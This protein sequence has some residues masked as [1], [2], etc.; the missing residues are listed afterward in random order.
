METRRPAGTIGQT[1]GNMNPSSLGHREKIKDRNKKI[2]NRHLLQEETEGGEAILL[3]NQEERDR[4]R[5]FT[6]SILSN[7][8]LKIIEQ[9]TG[10]TTEIEQTSKGEAPEKTRV[11]K[12]RWVSR[13]WTSNTVTSTKDPKEGGRMYVTSNKRN[14]KL[15]RSP[16]PSGKEH[17][18]ELYSVRKK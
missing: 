7:L 9:K 14:G 16:G 12:R 18:K 2:N 15:P 8:F 1:L 5:T 10:G 6:S 17:T 13:R 4:R 3:K 11:R